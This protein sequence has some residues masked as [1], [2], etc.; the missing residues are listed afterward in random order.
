M[1]KDDTPAGGLLS[2]MVKFVRNPT[3]NWSDLDALD[4]NRDSQYSKQVLK[5][6]IERKRRNDFVRKREFDQLR[7]LRQSGT[8]GGK[9]MRDALARASLFS[10]SMASPDER[11]GTIKKIDE[12][13]AQMSQQWW[14]G[15]EQGLPPTQ[16]PAIAAEPSAP[17]MPNP[18]Q[19]ATVLPPVAVP[20]VPPSVTVRADAVSV[21]GAAALD[22]G[23]AYAP[24]APM[25]LT[26][27]RDKA[28][29]PV[30]LGVAFAAAAPAQ[31]PGLQLPTPTPMPEPEAFEHDPDL[32]E[33]AIRFASGDFKGAEAGLKELLA[34]YL[35]D[36]PQQHAVWL[37]LFDLYRATGQQDP[38]DMLAIEYAARFG[39]SAPLWFSMPEQ[40]GLQAHSDAATPRSTQLEH[41]WSAP[42]ALTQQS[43]AA[44]QAS[45]ARS[46]SPWTL[47]WSR[48]TEIEAPAVPALAQ[49]FE[50]WAGRE[51]QIRFVG[52]QALQ[53]LLQAHTQS[54]DRSSG[55]AWWRLRMA[56]LRLM[57]LHDEFEFV[58]LDY[59]VTYEV[60]P[61]SWVSPHCSYSGDDGAPSAAVPDASDSDL[62]QSGFPVSQPARADETALAALQGQID[63]D[64]APLLQP[65]EDMVRPGMPLV[66]SC[67][68]LIRID[69]A[70]VGSVLNWAAEQQAQGRAVHFTQ[71]HRLVAVL[72][73]VIGINEH[74][75]V[76]LRKN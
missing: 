60:S 63:G 59:C 46:A 62:L 14:K 24:T 38:F 22:Q 43:A 76:V 13:E 10:S 64:A 69:F 7:K 72:F 52:V 71:L 11:A 17:G 34:L 25:D 20:L 75:R 21:A 35:Q 48:L 4:D 53:N 1:S 65:L 67:G 44:L 47:N 58:A 56:A 28:A 30:S 31:A 37:T 49:Q 61:P 9:R 73:N 8:Q 45:L 36:E 18:S 2:K 6:M 39:R 68:R 70:A 19:G 42:P 23:H 32:E 15:K 12:I 3:V 54:G 50:D 5:E 66:V 51:V 27:I 29:A 55:P 16:A 26:M 40:L 41:S 33:A 74:A 57:G